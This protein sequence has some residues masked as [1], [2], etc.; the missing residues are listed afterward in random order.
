MFADTELIWQ[1]L[2]V[3]PKLIPTTKWTENLWPEAIFTKNCCNY[4]LA[5]AC[6]G[7]NKVAAD[8]FKNCSKNWMTTKKLLA[9]LAFLKGDCATL[10]WL[11][12]LFFDVDRNLLFSPWNAREVNRGVQCFFVC[13]S[14]YRYLHIMTRGWLAKRHQLTTENVAHILQ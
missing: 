10:Q 2:K 5:H 4:F 13:F 3:I 12:I 11:S 1:K 8:N 6:L 7:T 9:K 14:A